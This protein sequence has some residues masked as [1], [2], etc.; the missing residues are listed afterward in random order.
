M[1][2]LLDWI[3]DRLGYQRKHSCTDRIIN[4]WE[5]PRYGCVIH[6]IDFA[7]TQELLD[8]CFIPP[9][10]EIDFLDYPKI[11]ETDIGKITIEIK[12]E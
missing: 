12:E 7:T 4:S 2:K 6:P 10:T 3:A 8:D 1:R 9:M 5:P 11:I